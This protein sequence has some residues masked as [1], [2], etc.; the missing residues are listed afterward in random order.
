M[1]MA[2]VLGMEKPLV[3]AC[4]KVVVGGGGGGAT[5]TRVTVE[6]GNG[7]I[8]M[9]ANCYFL[10]DVEAAQC[11]VPADRTRELAAI[12]E[13]N[14]G[15]FNRTVAAALAAGATAVETEVAEVDAFNCGEP[16]ALRALAGALL[17]PR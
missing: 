17:C 10:V 4:G 6:H 1:E 15:Q 5:A 16:G 11:A 14:F 2:A 9:L 8:H 12:G 3:F 13:A 7:A